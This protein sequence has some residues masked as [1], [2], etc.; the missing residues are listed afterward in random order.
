MKLSIKVLSILAFIFAMNFSVTAQQTDRGPRNPEQKVKKLTARL[1]EKLSLDQYQ[2]ER[3][4]QINLA[5][6]RSVQ[7]ARAANKGDKE[8]MKAIRMNIRTTTMNEMKTVLTPDQYV[9]YEE[10][11]ANRKGKGK[12]KKRRRK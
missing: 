9:A 4:E 1:V 10:I 3:V 11:L 8:A 7:E 6:V 2:A 5:H 12:K